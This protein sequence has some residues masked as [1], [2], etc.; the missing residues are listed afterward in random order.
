VWISDSFA[1]S[2]ARGKQAG[3]RLL[4]LASLDNLVAFLLGD[5]MARKPRLFAQ[6]VLY[7]VI[8]RGDYRQKTFFKVDRLGSGV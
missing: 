6:G 4:I 8:V 5:R 2:A 1:G 3:V 7:H